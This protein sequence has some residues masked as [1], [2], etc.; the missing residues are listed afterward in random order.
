MAQMGKE[1]F[2]FILPHF[3]GDIRT[4]RELQNR[5]TVLYKAQQV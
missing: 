1:K 2:E 3:V 4:S 5:E